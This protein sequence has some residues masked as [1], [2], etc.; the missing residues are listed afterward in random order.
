M[1]VFRDVLGT[2]NRG[3]AVAEHETDDIDQIGNI[4]IKSAVAVHIG[5]GRARQQFA[6]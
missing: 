6:A 1:N 4:R 5:L 2:G 3:G